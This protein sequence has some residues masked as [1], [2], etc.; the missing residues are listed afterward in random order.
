MDVVPPYIVPEASRFIADLNNQYI[1]CLLNKI[2]K[3]RAKFL[4]KP[5]PF[6]PG[7]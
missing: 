4:P 6:Y 2:E 7:L 1:I 3:K 5:I